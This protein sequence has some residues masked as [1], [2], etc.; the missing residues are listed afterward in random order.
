MVRLFGRDDQQT[1][2]DAFW[3]QVETEIGEPVLA[4][5]LGQ[6]LSGREEQ[7]P[8]WGLLYH[9][10]TAFHFHHFAQQNWFSSLVRNGARDASGTASRPVKE[11]EITYTIPLAQVAR[12][13]YE[14][15]RSWFRRVFVS[16]P[17]VVS[18]I[19]AFESTE[20]FRFTVENNRREFLASLRSVIG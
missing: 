18:L 20:P 19:G 6:Y 16:P 2:V 12:L 11:R 10:A 5:T 4:H 7:G 8:L 9:G 15:E 1:S 13:E 3:K 14:E 17:A